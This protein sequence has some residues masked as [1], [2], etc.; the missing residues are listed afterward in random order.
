MELNRRL[1]RVAVTCLI[2]VGW[3]VV[4]AEALQIKDVSIDKTVF[5]P[6][7]GQHLDISF[8]L[9]TEASV[10]ALVLDAD[11]FPVA[12]LADARLC[13]P[14]VTVLRWNGRDDAGAVVPN[15][16]YTV[17]IEAVT[18][19]GV[20]SVFDSAS[21]S[22]GE[23]IGY[24]PVEMDRSAGRIRFTTATAVRVQLL[25]GIVDGPLM[26]TIT[27][28]QPYPAGNHE[29]AWDGYDESHITKVW[30]N[31]RFKL[32]ARAYKL[33]N[34][35]VITQGNATD[36]MD[37]WSATA[38]KQ[39]MTAVQ[40][41]ISTKK[42]LASRVYGKT[43]RAKALSDGRVRLGSPYLSGRFKNQ[44]AR[45]TLE[46]IPAASKTGKSA[47]VDIRISVDK[48]FK[49]ILDEQRYEYVMY[50][51]GVLQG[52]QETGFSPYSWTLDTTEMSAG[53]H[54]V[55]VNIATVDGQTGAAST[56]IEVAE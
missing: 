36:Y 34:L 52:E 31:K 15:E 20:K 51:D 1:L 27:D 8:R 25:A 29:V 46:S 12:T 2:L 11:L 37:Y 40:Y 6:T 41:R 24:F 49:Q 48:V 55:T 21:V 3:A 33:P 7:A 32:L 4:G 42:G 54:L 30:D 50:V 35:C 43:A 10:T 39:G 26:A 56:W 28:W 9:D 45:F 19:L 17:R 18:D 14:G 5:N 53:K 38:A 13:R 47:P 44:A 23:S 22:G 16:A